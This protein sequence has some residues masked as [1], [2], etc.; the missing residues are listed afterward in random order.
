MLQWVPPGPPEATTCPRWPSLGPPNGFSCVCLDPP[1][2]LFQEYLPPPTPPRI[3]KF[4]LAPSLGSHH[5]NPQMAPGHFYGTPPSYPLNTPT[6]L[7]IPFRTL[8]RTPRTH[9]VPPPPP[10]TF[11]DPLNAPLLR[12]PIAAPPE[13]FIPL[14][15]G[16]GNEPPPI[17]ACS[18]GLGGGYRWFC[19]GGGPPAAATLCRG[20][21]GGGAECGGR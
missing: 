6:C 13:P 1:S 21:R 19:G 8:F 17:T 14:R 18:G 10:Q 7:Q 12:L 5:Q 15:P 3:S 4:P 11:W 9:L 2:A 20:V 16:S